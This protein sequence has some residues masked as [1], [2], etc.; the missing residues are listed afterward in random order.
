[1][2]VRMQHRGARGKVLRTRRRPWTVSALIL[3]VL[4]A[5]GF[6]SACAH[7]HANAPSDT[8]PLMVPAPPPHQVEPVEATPP[9]DIPLPQE[10]PRRTPARPAPTPARPETPKPE[11]RA[12]APK[13]EPE[14]AKPAEEPAKPP[15]TTL[16]T[17][18]AG[19]EG[20]VERDI[21]AMLGRASDNLN[22]ID[23]RALNAD[24]RMQYDTA[25][26]FIRQA[27]DALRAKNL[28]FARNL[29]DKAAALAAQ[30]GGR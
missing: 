12:E 21:R 28:V 11:P 5:G 22:H 8:P 15:A 7:A 30:L 16:Q 2:L 18:P 29:A 4:M 14:P 24:A 9:P 27:E 13:S 1:M 25:K 26:R 20:E 10:P 6:A 19:T 23:Y 3:I 17:T